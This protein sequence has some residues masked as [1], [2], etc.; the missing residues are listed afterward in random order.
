MEPDAKEEAYEETGPL[1]QLSDYNPSQDLT[2][3]EEVVIERIG[4]ASDG[5]P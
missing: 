1:E 2:R 3:L 5:Q 4:R